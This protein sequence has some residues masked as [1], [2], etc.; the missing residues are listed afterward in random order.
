MMPVSGRDFSLDT[1][2]ALLDAIV[3]KYPLIPRFREWFALATPPEQFCILRHDVDRKPRNS[4]AMARLEA[5]RKVRACYYF[6]VPHT[7]NVDVIREIESL[8]HEIGY[9]YENLSTC[10]G[11]MDKALDD[12]RRNLATLRG[13][14]RIDTVCMHGSP[15]SPHTNSD[16]WVHIAGNTQLRSELALAGDAQLDMD[17]ADIA[18]LTD[19]GRS[20]RPG[21][22]NLRDRVDSGVLID[23]AS[24]RELHQY[25]RTAPPSKAGHSNPSRALVR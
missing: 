9:H 8:G 7:F 21:R 20:W 10:N 24:T 3:D 15:L 13:I 17:F 16:L 11:Q 5:G 19:T 4:L 6:R 22:A 14:A 23:V 2:A 12:F 1:Y 25:L 18:Y